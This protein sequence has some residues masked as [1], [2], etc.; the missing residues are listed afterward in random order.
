MMF[1]IVFV[2]IFRIRL[3]Q[4]EDFVCVCVCDRELNRYRCY[5]MFYA[6]STK[7]KYLHVKFGFTVCDT[8][9]SISVLWSEKFGK[10]EAEI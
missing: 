4:K 7:Q 9:H 10:N 2:L 3:K 6:Q 5:L 8:F 1:H